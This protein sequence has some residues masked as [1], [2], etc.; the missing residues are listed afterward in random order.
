[1]SKSRVNRVYY[2]S[3]RVH[4]ESRL[5]G[6]V[7]HGVSRT[8][9]RNGQLALEERYWN[10]RLHG[11]CRA[12]TEHGVALGEFTMTHG[13]GI[14]RAWHTNGQIRLEI[15]TLEARF[16]G[17]V[18]T[19][20]RDG[21][22]AGEDFYISGDPVSRSAYLKAAKSRPDWPQYAS[23][24]KGKLVR[25]N[26]KVE[27]E[28]HEGFV[29]SILE[30]SLVVEAKEWLSESRQGTRRVKIHSLGKFRSEKAASRFVAA[31]YTAGATEVHVAG[32]YQGSKPGVFADWMLVGLPKSKALRAKVRAICNELSVRTGAGFEPEKDIGESC[33]YGL[34]A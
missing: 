7:L 32:I 15:G 21:T 8:W 14:Q 29:Q 17:R 9:H 3:G 22:L 19:W 34:L 33:L 20:L 5:K 26:R 6:G 18:R 12:W 31:L 24:R 13:T 2:R 11:V 23:E 4:R 10:G 27:L 25:R 16:H 30:G 1:M 28:E